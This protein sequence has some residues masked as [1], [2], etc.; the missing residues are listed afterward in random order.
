MVL[1]L[2]KGSHGY[3]ADFYKVSVKLRKSFTGLWGSKGA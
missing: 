1:K 2:L 3:S